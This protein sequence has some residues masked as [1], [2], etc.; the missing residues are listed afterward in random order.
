M[1]LRPYPRV[2]NVAGKG[3]LAC[4]LCSNEPLVIVG[5]RINQV[6]DDFLDGPTVRPGLRGGR[7]RAER[8]ELR[9]GF[10]NNA[11]QFVSD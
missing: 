11:S 5:C 2:L 3:E 10:V 9:G 7:H 1:V 4:P 6:P 8:S